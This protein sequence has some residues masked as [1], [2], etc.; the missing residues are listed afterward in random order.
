[1]IPRYLLENRL[2]IYMSFRSTHHIKFEISEKLKLKEQIVSEV[3]EICEKRKLE[4][5]SFTHDD[6][7]KM[8]NFRK[9][10][11]NINEEIN[12]LEKELRK[13]IIIIIT[14]IQNNKWRRDSVF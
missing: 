12:E 7:M 10:I 8:D 6:K 14:T 3:R 2:F 13:K 4:I 5:R 9:D 1:M 11:S